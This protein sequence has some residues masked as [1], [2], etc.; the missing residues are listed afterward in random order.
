M[1]QE[2]HNKLAPANARK[3]AGYVDGTQI[4]K[5]KKMTLSAANTSGCRGVTYDRKSNK[6]RAALKFKGK[7]MH[8]GSYSNFE[9]AVKARQ[10]AEREYFGEFLEDIR[11]ED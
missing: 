8:F 5:I 2:C 1:C 11:Q 6:Y 3:S 4:S 7:L 10:A 9:D